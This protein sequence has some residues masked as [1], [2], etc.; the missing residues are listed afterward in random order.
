MAD[1]TSLISLEFKRFSIP[2]AVTIP[3][4]GMKLLMTI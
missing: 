3:V 4:D 2:P 1:H